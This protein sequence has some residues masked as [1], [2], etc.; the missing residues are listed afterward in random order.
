MRL[1]DQAVKRLPAPKRGNKV[2][3][4]DV[5]KGFGCRVTAAGQRAFVLNYRRKVDGRQRQI[6]IGS[7]PD[8]GTHAAREEAKRLKRKVDGGGDPVGDIQSSRAAA[9][10]AELCARFEREVLPRNRPSTQPGYRQQIRADI[11]PA[12]GRMKVAAV[13]YSDIDAI[14]RKISA[15]APGPTLTASAPCCRAYLASQSA[16]ACAT[17]IRVAA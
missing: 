15:R 11:L 6:T 8:W 9:T 5:V 14:H 16:G 4:D 2:T 13:A 1:T 7:L 10:V 3:F 17:T 12:L